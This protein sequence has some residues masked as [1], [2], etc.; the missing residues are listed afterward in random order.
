MS[1]KS[2]MIGNWLEETY[3]LVGECEILTP[4]L[5]P[6]A[7]S[8]RKRMDEALTP[9][10]SKR[11]RAATP[12][13]IDE[14]ATSIVSLPSTSTARTSRSTSPS[15]ASKTSRNSS[16]TKK[17]KDRVAILSAPHLLVKTPAQT[18]TWKKQD[19]AT[20]VP[21]FTQLIEY[22]NDST[23]DTDD[24]PN[25]QDVARERSIFRGVNRCVKR[26]LNE[27]QWSEEVVRPTL[28]AAKARS[29]RRRGLPDDSLLD[30]D[31]ENDIDVI[32]V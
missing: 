28:E 8:K 29:R 2:Q 3:G 30:D 14:D 18:V 17:Q 26:G 32:N 20:H 6:T 21:L 7:S 9:R 22:L 24:E 11:T 25:V 13:G 31:S 5:S 4:P 16:P 23:A 27:D 12:P 1:L 10:A 19:E 15:K